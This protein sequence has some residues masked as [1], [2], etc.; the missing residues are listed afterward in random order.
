MKK[1]KKTDDEFSKREAKARFEAALRG[2][3]DVGPK[4]MKDIPPKRP[5]DDMPKDD[6]EA[7]IAWAKR[8]LYGKIRSALRNVSAQDL[9]A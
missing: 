3:R 4:P 7:L 8:K 9:A 6:P 5:V 2:S 1:Q